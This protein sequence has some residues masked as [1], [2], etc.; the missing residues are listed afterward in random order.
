MNPFFIS[1]E[2]PWEDL[3]E[4]LSRQIVGYTDELM[5]VRVRFEKGAIGHPHAHEIHD[6]I[7]YV[8]CGSFEAE[9]EGEKKILVAGDAYIAPKHFVHG[10]VALEEGSELLDLFS[11]AREDFLK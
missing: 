2:Q 1:K 8:I 6:Q 5:G 3:G 7:G 11:P 4:G 10:A 9:I